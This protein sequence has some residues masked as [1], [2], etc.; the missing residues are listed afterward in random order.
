VAPNVCETYISRKKPK[1]RES[2]TVDII[3]SVAE[4]AVCS[5]EGRSQRR[6]LLKENLEGTGVVAILPDCTQID[7]RRFLFESNGDL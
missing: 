2:I 3:S 7:E 6:A 1:T 5:C 4:S